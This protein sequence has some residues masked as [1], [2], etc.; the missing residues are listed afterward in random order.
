MPAGV[1]GR[2]ASIAF[3]LFAA[4]SWNVAASVTKGAYF[5]ST[6]GLKLQPARV[7][8]EAMGQPFLGTGDLGDIEAPDLEW[9]GRS[10]Y[11]DHMYIWDAAAMGSPA[12][13]TISTSVSGQTTSYQHII[14]LATTNNGRGVTIAADKSLYVDELTSAKIYGFMEAV[15]DGG[16]MDRTYK[17]LGSRPTNISSVNVAATV[18]GANY[19]S[20]A[21]RI[22]RKQGV[23]RLNVQGA[24]AL[25]AGDAQTVE[26]VEY[27]F[28]RPQDGPHVFGQDYITEPADSGF[29]TF[30]VKVKWARMAA[31]NASSLY[32][33][34]RTNTLWKGDLT[35]TGAFINSTDAFQRKYQWPQL[36]LDDWNGADIDGA[37]QVK[38][39]ATFTAKM[40]A[41]SPAGM[42][43][44]RPMR[45][46]LIN[47]KDTAAF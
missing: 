28:E 11:D 47:T 2:E 24:S 46:T 42:P 10:R 23:F 21:N 8:D 34:L 30:S 26:T 37:G 41:T 29:P 40:A 38:P 4:N 39:E 20:L 6:A 1:T 13:A 33:A 18:A 25:A 15:G 35:Y 3:A 27:S 31:T 5:R 43:F 16:V 22:F 19:P 17:T 45:L 7:N 9:V 14:D 32:A 36:E 44:V 12:A